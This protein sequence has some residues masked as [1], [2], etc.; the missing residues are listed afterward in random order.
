MESSNLVVGKRYWY[1]WANDYSARSGL[2]IGM[3]TENALF[4]YTKDEC[5]VVKLKDIH[6]EDT[7]KSPKSSFFR[8]W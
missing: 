2:L 8:M 6:C 5:W 7:I 4:Q 3:T 1:R